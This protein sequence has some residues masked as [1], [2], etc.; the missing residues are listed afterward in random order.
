MKWVTQLERASFCHKH[1]IYNDTHP[2]S[3]GGFDRQAKALY[4]RRAK[5]DQTIIISSV[6]NG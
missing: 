2:Q 5:K 3:P 6:S 1:D 4:T